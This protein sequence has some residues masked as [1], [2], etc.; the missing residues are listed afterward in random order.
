[1][2]R[3]AMEFSALGASLEVV[4]KDGPNGL[5]A[6]GMKKSS[7]FYVAGS[8]AVTISG[9]VK[10]HKKDIG[11]IEVGNAVV[12]VTN[13]LGQS[14]GIEIIDQGTYTFTGIQPIPGGVIIAGLEY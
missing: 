13:L 3:Q 12:D 4:I 14:V 6:I 11:L 10:W 9:G 7:N 1:M 5:V 8:S 2:Y